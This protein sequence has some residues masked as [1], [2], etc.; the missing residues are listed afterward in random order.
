M[1]SLERIQACDPP[2]AET[3]VHVDGADSSILAALRDRSPTIRVLVSQELVGPGGARSRLI[4]AASHEW[5][6]NFDDDSHPADRDYFAR[7]AQAAERWPKAAVF[8]AVTVDASG[9]RED[10]TS[11]G[12]AREVAVF[13]GCGCVYRKSWFQRTAGYVPVPVAYFVEETDL[14]LQLRALGGQIIEIPELRICHE[15]ATQQLEDP[16]RTAHSIANIALLGYLRFPVSL[17]LLVPCQILSR[18]GWLIRRGWWK[19]IGTGLLMIPRHLAKY[20]GYRKRMPA[21]TVLSW[22]AHRHRKS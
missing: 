2:P 22:L 11:G 10:G 12:T 1:E 17:W 3:L 13:S 8:S 5:V 21:K 14:S 7:I 4:H 6:A 18:I 16:V 15:G 20:A 9:V 19:G